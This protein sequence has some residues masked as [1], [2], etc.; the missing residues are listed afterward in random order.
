[1]AMRNL[2]AL[3]VTAFL[4]VVPLGCKRSTV[5]ENQPAISSRHDGTQWLAWSNRERVQFVAAYV[6]GYEM[7]VH[8]ACDTADHLLDLKANCV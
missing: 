4:C 8:N 2:G 7:G 5:Q 1:M 3:V 6:D